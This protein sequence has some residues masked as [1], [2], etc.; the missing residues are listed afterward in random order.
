METL[1]VD[2]P[3][4][5]DF[6][7]GNVLTQERSDELTLIMKSEN[8]QESAMSEEQK[9]EKRATAPSLENLFDETVQLKGES[10]QLKKNWISDSQMEV[11]GLSN[12]TLHSF[13][14]EAEKLGKKITYTRTIQVKISD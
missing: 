8:V 1:Q 12:T 6:L 2:N 4:K 7:E 13:V 9:Q 10:S 11:E 5:V 14:L 3:T